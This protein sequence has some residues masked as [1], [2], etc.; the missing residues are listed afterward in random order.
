METLA[1][2]MLRYVIASNDSLRNCHPFATVTVAV[3][4]LAVL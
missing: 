4:C 1:K 2:L 3:P